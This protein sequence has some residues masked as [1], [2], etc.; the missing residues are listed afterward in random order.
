MKKLTLILAGLFLL[1]SVSAFA[2]S[3]VKVSAKIKTCFEKDF[4]LSSDVTWTK[5][6]E[7]YLA[8]FKSMEQSLMAAYNEEGELL[9]VSRSIPLAKLPL[10]VSLALQNKYAGYT[11]N[12]SVIELFAGG[13]TYFISAENGKYKVRIQADTAGQLNVISKTKK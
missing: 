6:E 10:G 2:T 12:D 3:D 7:V 5:A 13:T 1:F 4:A 8:S 9:G 11:I